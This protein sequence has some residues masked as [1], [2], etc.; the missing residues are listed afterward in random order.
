MI[1]KNWIYKLFVP[2]A[3][4]MLS[5]FFT[6]SCKRSWSDEPT[7]SLKTKALFQ[8]SVVT[9]GSLQVFTFAGDG[10]ANLFNSPGGVAIDNSG[11]IYVADAGKN[12]IRKI[13]PFG[14]TSTLAGNGAAGSH[15]DANGANATFNSPTG[16]AVDASGNIFVADKGNHRIRMV[17]QS[18][19][20]ST[21]AGS[22]SGFFDAPDITA[23]FASPSGITLDRAGNIYVADTKNNCIRFID[24]SRNVHTLAGLP[25][26]PAGH[27]SGSIGTARFFYPVGITIDAFNNILVTDSTSI[28]RIFGGFVHTLAGGESIGF[29]DKTGTN[30]RFN[31]P[32]GMTTDA[33]GNV[34]V[35]DRYNHRIRLVTPAGVVSTYAGNGAA[36]FKD[37]APVNAS[38]NS[39][40]GIATDATGNI[41]VGDTRNNRIRQIGLIAIGNPLSA[42]Y[43]SLVLKTDFTLWATGNNFF[44]QLGNGT[45]TSANTPAKLM[46][47]VQA[48]SAGYM[49][50]LIL[51]T[52]NTLWAAGDNTSGQLGTGIHNDFESI[53]VKIMDNVIA[54]AAG[55]SHS[56]ILKKDNSLWSAGWNDR[57][58]LGD[59][60]NL[61]KRSPV[62]IMDNVKAIAA[63]SSHNLILKTDNTLWADGFN[64]YGQ[65]G[66]GT[67]TDRNTPVK[68]MDNIKA[69]AAGDAHSLILKMDN[70]LWVAGN[71][72]NGQLGDGTN[73]NKNT[74]VKIMDNVIAISGGANHSLILKGDN[75][76]WT[77]GSN[78]YGQL[79]DGSTTNR[80]TPVKVMDNVL[81]IEAGELHSLI[82]KTDLSCWGTGYNADG[83][84]GD[85]TIQNKSTWVRMLLQYQ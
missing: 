12:R 4:Y 53:P 54:M 36:T 79:G 17:T 82:L 21:I 45:M 77:T 62:K 1:K 58:Q 23:E 61:P 20:V 81:T 28:R 67:N 65:L 46:D 74:P 50:T 26:Q 10:T 48:I 38:F 29:D 72:V 85:G 49:H 71:N 6:E 59:G 69:I 15:D 51:K 80:N 16:I 83:E 35:A 44:G 32:A 27:D 2:A 66:D 22:D 52:D 47:N 18:G 78:L 40:Y 70:S 73:T 31:G 11:N 19:A 13:T 9:T 37:G 24:L 60:T 43:Q 30:A 33:S 57:G 68:V 3:V 5:I 14:D 34:Y 63:G 7:A 25:N 76:L 8:N 42:G 55:G 75:S 39:P 41:Y 64:F 56:L 84:L